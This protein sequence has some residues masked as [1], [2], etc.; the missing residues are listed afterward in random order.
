MAATHSREH[1]R[2]LAERIQGCERRKSG[3]LRKARSRGA[4][5]GCIA[6][7]NRHCH[8]TMSKDSASWLCLLR[9]P[10]NPVLVRR[11]S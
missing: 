6:S 3:L 2:S 9:D 8:I 11:E 5:R 1:W 7:H 10:M 4:P